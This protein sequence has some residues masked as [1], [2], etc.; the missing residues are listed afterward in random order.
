ME[1]EEKSVGL[2][3]I[4]F[5]KAEHHFEAR[6]FQNPCCSQYCTLGCLPCIPSNSLELRRWM[7]LHIGLLAG[8]AVEAVGGSG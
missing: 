2:T 8:E 1:R 5:C 3:T 6:K 4:F 7:C